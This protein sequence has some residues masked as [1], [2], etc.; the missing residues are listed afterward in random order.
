MAGCTAALEGIRVVDFSHVYQGPVGT[1]LMADFGADVI[2]IE[3]PGSGDWSRSWGPYVDGVSMPFASLNRNKRSVALDLRTEGGKQ[4]IHRLVLTADVLVH[5][6]RPGT[7]ERLGLGYE[8]L[9]VVH[10]RL[11][12]ARSSGWGDR[13]PYVER[14]RGGHDVLARAEA[15]WFEPLGADGLPVPVGMSADYPAG[16]LLVQGILMALLARERT[17]RGQ[18]VTT[19]LFSAAFHAHTWEGGGI[20]NRERISAQVGIEVTEKVIRKAF[21]TRDSFIEISPVFSSDALRDL[22]LALGI[23]DLSQDPR[24]ATD[25]DRLE[26]A[27]EINDVLA[28]RFMEKTTDEWIA[29]LEPLGIL[30]GHVNSFEEAAADPQL[31]ANEMVVEMDHPRAG[32]LKLFGTPV[33]LY[34]TPATLRMPPP[35]LGQHTEE[36]L[37]ELGYSSEEIAEF[38]R[39]GVFGR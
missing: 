12:Y 16:L 20:L 14:G 28:G 4:I 39:Q 19:D 2:K 27:E 29:Y 17:G 26:R 6:F 37:A 38:D 31:A 18:L 25:A 3:R 1:Q 8:D 23:G 33:R 21:R 10:P 11:V 7:M 22:S 34:G 32:T 5:N 35:D 9:A 15:G 36:V 24:Y 13:G 30:C